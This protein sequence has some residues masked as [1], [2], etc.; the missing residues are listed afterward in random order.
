MEPPPITLGSLPHRS[1]SFLESNLNLSR[2][3]S[4]ISASLRIIKQNLLSALFFLRN[5]NTTNTPPS[6]ISSKEATPAEAL[7]SSP[8]QEPP[9][10]SVLPDE[11]T[12]IP[13]APPTS[14]QRP[15]VKRALLIGISEIRRPY[16]VQLS[17]SSLPPSSTSSQSTAQDGVEA[18][19]QLKTKKKPTLSRRMEVMRKDNPPPNSPELAAAYPVLQSPRGTMMWSEI[20]SV[21]KSAAPSDRKDSGDSLVY[22]PSR[23]TKLIGPHR[24]VELMRDTLIEKYGYANEDITVLIDDDLE[25]QLQPTKANILKKIDELVKDI[26]AGDILFF[27]YTGHGDQQDTDDPAEEDRKNEVMPTCDGKAIL[28]DVLHQRL[29]APLPVGSKLFAVCDS[30]HSGSLLDLFHFR[31]NGVW[32]PWLSKGERRTLTVY[33]MRTRRLARMFTPPTSSR[34]GTIQRSIEDILDADSPQAPTISM[35]SMSFSQPDAVDSL[36]VQEIPVQ[37]GRKATASSSS[38]RFT[39]VPPKRA[40]TVLHI[41][42][43]KDKAVSDEPNALPWLNEPD[44]DRNLFLSPERIFCDGGCRETCLKNEPPRADVICL[45]ATDDSELSWANDQGHSLTYKLCHILQSDPNP[46]LHSLLTY[47]SHA[48]HKDYLPMHED[49]RKFRKDCREINEKRMRKGLEPRPVAPTE[50]NNFQHPVMSSHEPLDMHTM[51]WEP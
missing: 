17:G 30:C 33:N 26:E 43:I 34:P 11:P 29:V 47:V 35:A 19:S 39:R 10:P 5:S 22:D 20:G 31:C 49:G 1:G 46:T 4:L 9:V 51:R 37:R 41:D 24:D 23:F 12:A 8:V 48:F 28:D 27:L 3:F 45:S 6:A 36:H 32:V 42:T 21:S 7:P 40:K 50:I 44:Q 38:S 15:P 18:K 13:P 2:L 16:D 25:D 14:A